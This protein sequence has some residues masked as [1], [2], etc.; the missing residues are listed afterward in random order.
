MRLRG[1][2]TCLRLPPYS[3]LN[4]S[5]KLSGGQR[6]FLSGKGYWPWL[7]LGHQQLSS[8]CVRRDQKCKFKWCHPRYNI[9]DWMWEHDRTC[10]FVVYVTAASNSK[11]WLPTIAW[12]CDAA[13][14]FTNFDSDENTATTPCA[15]GRNYWR[16][17]GYQQRR[18]KELTLTPSW[19]LQLLWCWLSVAFKII[20]TP[21]VTNNRVNKSKRV[22]KNTGQQT[23]SPTKPAKMV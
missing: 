10:H 2:D 16:K 6:L 21:R 9:H 15:F 1:T 4:V 14:C 11:A 18:W 17:V 7:L 13:L 12:W 8:L 19:F 5:F 23:R 3:E 20:H 22:N